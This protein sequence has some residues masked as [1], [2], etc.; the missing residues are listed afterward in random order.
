[1][2]ERAFGELKALHASNDGEVARPASDIPPDIDF[3]T[4]PDEKIPTVQFRDVDM[5]GDVDI[6]ISNPAPGQPGWLENTLGHEAETLFKNPIFD[7][8]TPTAMASADLDG[9]GKPDIVIG[10]ISGAK[11]FFNHG[12]WDMTD[13]GIRLDTPRAIVLD[14]VNGDGDV[15]VLIRDSRDLL[16][17]QNHHGI[18]GTH[19][20]AWPNLGDNGILSTANIDLTS[21]EKEILVFDSHTQNLGVIAHHQNTWKCFRSIAPV[22]AQ[23]ILIKDINNDGAD[24]VFIEDEAGRTLIFESNGKGGLSHSTADENAPTICGTGTTDTT[25][26]EEEHTHPQPASP[27]LMDSSFNPPSSERAVLPESSDTIEKHFSSAHS[28]AETDPLHEKVTLTEISGTSRSDLIFGG[29]DSEHISGHE[30]HDL[31]FAGPGDDIVHGGSQADMLYGGSGDDLMYGERGWD[32]MHG[33]KGDDT[34]YGND[35]NDV[36]FGRKGSDILHGGKGDDLLFGSYG[37]DTIHG[38]LGRDYIDGGN[39]NDLFFYDNPNE[40]ND[41]IADFE[42]G[43]DAFHFTFG[44]ATL[45]STGN[46][47]EDLEGDAFLWDSNE[48]GG[49]SLYYDP[50]LSVND[51]ELLIATVDFVDDNDNLTLDDIVVT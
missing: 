24:D 45:L 35:G 20:M 11:I 14:D 33:G 10:H 51:N 39:G 27:G 47:T 2:S 50:D 15:D 23:T 42:I 44:T 5:D 48:E 38:D 30:G 32:F 12:S 36:L 17:F 6:V 18:L 13:L 1:M 22:S 46:G 28:M 29:S 16:L 37:D 26:P 3:V 40:G 8:I 25:Q 9:N 21:K 7:R 34:M 49:G 19:S 31:I 43:K 4:L 41:F